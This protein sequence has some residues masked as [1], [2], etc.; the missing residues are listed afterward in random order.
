MMTLSL[1]YVTATFQSVAMNTTPVMVFL[2]AVLTGQESFR[3]R[4]LSGQ[5]K[6]LGL[7]VSTVGA[8][9]MVFVSDTGR[10]DSSA[11]EADRWWV[12]CGLVGLAVLAMA[13]STLLMVRLFFL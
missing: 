13:V 12:G 2:L 5:A 9:A 3:L 10:S 11:L 1:R 4:S 7:V 6:L 8:V